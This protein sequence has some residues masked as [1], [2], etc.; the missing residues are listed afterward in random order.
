[1]QEPDVKRSAAPP[2]QYFTLTTTKPAFIT[3]IISMRQQAE[4]G[5]RHHTQ[6]RGD[7]LMTTKTMTIPNDHQCSTHG[8]EDD[9]GPGQKSVLCRYSQSQVYFGNMMR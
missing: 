6:Q 5:G 4:D 8:K 9:E 7:M 1:M 3:H 2:R